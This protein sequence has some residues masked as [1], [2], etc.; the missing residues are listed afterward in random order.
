MM[1]P[2]FMLY[3]MEEPCHSIIQFILL[4]LDIALA[5]HCREP[6]PLTPVKLIIIIESPIG[7]INLK[8]ICR[9]GTSSAKYLRLVG[10]TFGAEDFLARLG[11]CVLYVNLQY[12]LKKTIKT[13]YVQV[14]KLGHL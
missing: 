3:G 11:K 7:L 1:Q 2:S 5:F 14:G 6:G 10:V 13:A 12:K 4:Q 8:E 9:Y